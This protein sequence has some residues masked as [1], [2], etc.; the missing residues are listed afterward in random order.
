MIKISAKEFAEIVSG[1][2]IGIPENQI[3]NQ[4]PVIN[5]AA[6]TKDTFFTAFVGEKSDGHDFIPAAISNGA[7]FALVSKPVTGPAILV[8]DV[9]EAL[10]Q[11]TKA[12]RDQ[13]PAMQVIGITGS[14]GKTTT[15]DYLA[16]IL[17][18]IGNTIATEANLNTEIGVPL[19][20]L[21]ADEET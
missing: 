19:T 5:S 12:V 10:L 1:E 14:Q 21:R 15:K 8:K 6:A 9:G 13:L 2:L 11:L 18:Q 4:I 20:I 17:S 3:I 16:S 7:K